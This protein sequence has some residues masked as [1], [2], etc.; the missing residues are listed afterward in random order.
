[1]FDEPWYLASPCDR[2]ENESGSA[3]ETNTFEP[4]CS[5]GRPGFLD[6]E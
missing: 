2:A 3:S 5:T 6:V 1:M 4:K